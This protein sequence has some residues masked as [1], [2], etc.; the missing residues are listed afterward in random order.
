WILLL[1]EFNIE[2]LDKKGDEN[3]AADHLYQLKKPDLGKLTKAEIRDLFPDEQ[4]MAVSDKNKEPWW[5]LLLQEFNIEILDKKGDENLAADHLYRLKKP[6]LGKLT[7]AE[8]RDLFPDEQLMA[9]SD[10][11]KEPSFSVSKDMKNDAIE[12]YDEDGKEFIIN[13]QRVKPYQKDVL[14]GD[15]DDDITLDDEGEVT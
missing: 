15:K 14:E 13:K 10:K 6:D 5:I 8:I 11:N 3:L 12:L 2:I 1:Q 9:V 4:L 7:K